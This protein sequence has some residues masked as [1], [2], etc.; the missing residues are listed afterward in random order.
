MHA[1][2]CGKTAVN[3]TSKE[4]CSNSCN[5]TLPCIIS[6]V[7]MYTLYRVSSKDAKTKE[8]AKS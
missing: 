7:V 4:S 6:K 3:V 8:E 2:Y 5:C 1:S